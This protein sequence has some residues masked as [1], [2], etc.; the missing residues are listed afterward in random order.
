MRIWIV[1][2]LDKQWIFVVTSMPALWPLCDLFC[3]VIQVF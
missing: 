2:Y 3:A 1:C